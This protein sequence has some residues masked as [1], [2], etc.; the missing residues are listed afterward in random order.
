MALLVLV[1]A[2]DGSIDHGQ[3]VA[4]VAA[5]GQLQKADSQTQINH[6]LVAVVLAEFAQLH[7]CVL[8]RPTFYVF[9]VRCHIQNARR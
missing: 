9:Y 2:V 3:L 6:L 4:G 5:G 1:E 8:E 7:D